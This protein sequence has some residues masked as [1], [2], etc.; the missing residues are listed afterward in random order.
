MQILIILRFQIKFQ[1]DEEKAAMD[2]A[3]FVH[4][5]DKI[6]HNLY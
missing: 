5:K 3:F 4:L 2:A 6:L 1:R